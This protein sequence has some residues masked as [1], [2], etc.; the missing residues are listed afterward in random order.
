[1]NHIACSQINNA[2]THTHT[3]ACVCDK[4]KERGSK[5]ERERERKRESDRKNMS[6]EHKGIEVD[7]TWLH[8]LS[9]FLLKNTYA[10]WLSF[11]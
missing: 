6:F 11:A 2:F 1:M 4:E 9:T 3:C 7:D 10:Y 5:R 8:D